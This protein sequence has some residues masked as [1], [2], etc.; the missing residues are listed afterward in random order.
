MKVFLTSAS[1]YV[2]AEIAKVLQAEGHTV[3]DVPPGLVLDSM[4]CNF[5]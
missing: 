3:G 2:G 1:G 5:L 4:Y